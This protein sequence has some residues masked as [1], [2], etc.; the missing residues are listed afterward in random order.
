MPPERETELMPPK[1]LSEEL[2]HREHMARFPQRWSTGP[3][4]G[5]FLKALRD[6]KRIMA[7]VCPRCGR[8]QVPP[9][10]VCAVCRV[11]AT[12]FEEVGP[13]GTLRNFD[14][15]YYASPDP[16]TGQGREVPYAT[17]YVE[18]DGA[19]GGATFWHELHETDMTKLR[20]GLRVRAVFEE[21]GKR[22]GAI[23]DI[24]YFEIIEGEA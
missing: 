11:A 17:A 8:S 7:N 24:K 1:P 4:M 22:T 19:K 3:V 16:V 13:A 18:L 10:E 15:V 12:Q 9:R 6:E 5:K 20:R 21:D 2:I 23:T 14:V